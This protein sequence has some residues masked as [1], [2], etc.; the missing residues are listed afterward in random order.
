M[1]FA[2]MALHLRLVPAGASPWESLGSWR[3]TA[4]AGQSGAAFYWD[5]TKDEP[6][7][8]NGSG[9]GLTAIQPDGQTIT[10]ESAALTGCRLSGRIDGVPFSRIAYVVRAPSHWRVHLQTPAGMTA[11]DLRTLEDQHLQR[12]TGGSGVADL[13]SAPMPGAVAEVRVAL[14]DR[15]KAGD[16]LVVLEAMKLLQSLP[17][18]VAGVVTEIYCAPGDTVAGHAPLIKLDPEENT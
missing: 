10:V 9:S 3:L 2:A 11:T 15:V 8:M 18:P 16:T 6:I 17:A 13:L 1:A 5:T 12:A 14:G 7:R 4:P